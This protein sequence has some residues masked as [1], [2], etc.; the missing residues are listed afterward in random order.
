MEA[1]SRDASIGIGLFQKMTSCYAHP[2]TASL[3]ECLYMYMRQ[4]KSAEKTKTLL[5]SLLRLS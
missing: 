1:I 2:T 4:Q 5:W 3:E